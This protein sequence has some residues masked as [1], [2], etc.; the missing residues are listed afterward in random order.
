MIEI[1]KI[2]YESPKN[3]FKV[4]HEWM[5]GDADGTEYN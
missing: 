2:P 4:I 3:T 1:N 5:I